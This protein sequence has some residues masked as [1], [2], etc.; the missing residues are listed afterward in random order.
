MYH[1][2][3]SK[4]KQYSGTPA[5]VFHG[6]DVFAFVHDIEQGLTE[7]HM[8]ADFLYTELTWKAGIDSF[9]M[10]VGKT[11]PHFNEFMTRFTF[12]L[13]PF[14][15]PIFIIAGKE[16]AAFFPDFF[17]TDIL[18]SAHGNSP[19]ILYSNRK[20][21]WPA[22]TEGNSSNK[23]LI[24]SNAASLTVLLVKILI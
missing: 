1:T 18:F 10:R 8:K 16:S 4:G 14:E 17:Q 2:A 13:K 3:L 7:E 5:Q 20:S 22:T 23:N 11:P 6:Y 12:A 15:K 9:Y 21:V 24:R 19:A